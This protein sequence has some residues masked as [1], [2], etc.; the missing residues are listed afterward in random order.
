VEKFLIFEKIEFT[1]KANKSYLMNQIIDGRE[2]PF[3]PI[4]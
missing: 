3:T 2:W 4:N 1:E